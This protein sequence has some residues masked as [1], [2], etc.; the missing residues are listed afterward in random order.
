MRLS[1]R[2]PHARVPLLPEDPEVV[3]DLQDAIDP[4]YAQ[5]RYH[6]LLDYSAESPAPLSDEQRAWVREHRHAQGIR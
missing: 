4:V 6:A 3:I 1:E 5:G 2:L